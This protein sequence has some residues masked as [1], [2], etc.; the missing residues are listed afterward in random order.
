M[1]LYALLIL[2]II[3]SGSIFLNGI[4]T[5]DAIKAKGTKS[6]KSFG[7]ATSDIV[8]GD[9]LCSEISKSIISEYGAKL[10]STVPSVSL[11]DGESFNLTA[12]QITKNVDGKTLQMFGYNGQTPGPLLLVSQGNEIIVNFTNN[13]D[14]PTTVHWHGLR[15]DYT[16]DGVP[17]ISQDPVLPGETFQYFLKFPDTGIF[18]YH[19]H[20]RTEMQMELG[21]YGNILVEPK[22]SDIIP[23]DYQIPLIIDDISLTEDGLQEFDPEIVTYTLMGRFGNTMLINGETDFSLE[24]NQGDIVRFYLTNT[25]NTRTFDFGI[26]QQKIKLIADDASNYERQELVDSV[27][28]ASS[29]RRTVDVLFEQ[30]GQ[31]DITHSTPDETYVLGTISV[32]P[33]PKQ[34]D[35]DFYS[36]MQNDGVIQEIESFKKFFS[37]TPDLEIEFD[38]KIISMESN[39]SMNMEIHE[40]VI[41]EIEWEDEMPKMNAMSNEENTKWILRDMNSGKEGFDINYQVNVGDVKKIRLYNN[42]ES[43]HSMQHPIHIHGQRFLVLSEDG[44]PNENLSW[45]DSVL[46]PTGKTVDILVEFSNPGNWAMHCHIL[47]HAE[48]GMITEFVVN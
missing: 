18:I 5:A 15:L 26:E 17:E 34:L 28:L 44:I 48:A 38:V 21:L 33:S 3:F 46:I 39:N 10:I 41:E 22:N 1:K 23:V 2:F 47:E 31:Y 36:L 19:P 43:A 25:A 14:F 29:E 45:K 11:S 7:K 16:S 12:S 8:C 27:I 9:K 24:L 37:D 13:L 4:E 35:P 40:K 42:P 20:V 30:S 32:T 6:P